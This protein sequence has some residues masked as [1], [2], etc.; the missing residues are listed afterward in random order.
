VPHGPDPVGKTIF[1]GEYITDSKRDRLIW[2]E[3]VNRLDKI[4]VSANMGSTRPPN[5]LP[6]ALARFGKVRDHKLSVRLAFERRRIKSDE[7]APPPR[8]LVLIGTI[9]EPV[10]PNDS[11]YLR[12]RRVR[13]RI[14]REERKHRWRARQELLFGIDHKSILLPVIE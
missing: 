2:R 7:F 8:S 10:L 4:E 5:L 13:K 12:R 1:A 11:P 9:T 14:A 6:S 3:R